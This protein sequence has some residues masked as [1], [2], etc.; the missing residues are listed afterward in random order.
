[1]R[2]IATCA[3]GPRSGRSEAKDRRRRVDGDGPIWPR[4]A[5]KPPVPVRAPHARSC[6]DSIMEP[7]T[8]PKPPKSALADLIAASGLFG[9]LS[10]GDAATLASLAA[11]RQVA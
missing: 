5:R 2:S 7:I 4:G 9:E 11:L 3:A 6:Y 8:A 1:M 10:P